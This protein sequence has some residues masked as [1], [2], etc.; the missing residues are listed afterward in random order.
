MYKGLMETHHFT[1]P[2]KREDTQAKGFILVPQVFLSPWWSCLLCPWTERQVLEVSL[3][4]GAVIPSAEKNFSM[5]ST[6]VMKR[7]AP[8]RDW[9]NLS[10][11]YHLQV[12]ECYSQQRTWNFFHVRVEK[13]PFKKIIFICK[14]QN[15]TPRVIHPFA[16]VLEQCVIV[17]IFDR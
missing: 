1:L 7:E 17:N 14:M 13:L 10:G 12:R 3:A 15:P 16:V 6:T 8:P 4:R 11:K 9:T 5:L 2:G